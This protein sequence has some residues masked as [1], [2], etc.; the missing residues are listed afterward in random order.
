M[1]AQLPHVKIFIEIVCLRRLTIY[2]A[3]GAAH[4][5]TGLPEGSSLLA[6]TS[7]APVTRKCVYNAHEFSTD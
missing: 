3:D 5:I 6:S 1:T 7:A 2:R 4:A